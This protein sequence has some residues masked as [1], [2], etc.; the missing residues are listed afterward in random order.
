MKSKSIKQLFAFDFKKALAGPFNNGD[1]QKAEDLANVGQIDLFQFVIQ[2]I[3]FFKIKEKY[4][5]KII[6][7][8]YLESVCLA[9]QN[10]YYDFLNQQKNL[11]DTMKK[12]IQQPNPPLH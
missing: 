5:S 6:N 7:K 8:Y 9:L 4:L 10:H 3:K 1:Y 2:N 11:S 12:Y